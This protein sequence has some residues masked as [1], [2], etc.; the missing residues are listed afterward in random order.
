MAKVK[1][2]GPVEHDGKLLAIGKTVELPDDAVEA[3]I[4]AGAAELPTGKPAATPE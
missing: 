4:H 2:T 1:I 3:L